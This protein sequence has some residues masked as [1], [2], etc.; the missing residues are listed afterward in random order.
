[1]HLMHPPS[2]K[3]SAAEKKKAFAE[4]QYE[5]EQVGSRIEN[6]CTPSVS[7][8]YAAIALLSTDETTYLVNDLCT[9]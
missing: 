1:M 6:A 4:K 7:P 2:G 3:E 8:L 9:I 5:E